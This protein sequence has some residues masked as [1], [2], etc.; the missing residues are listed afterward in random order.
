MPIYYLS[1]FKVPV[2][3]DKVIEKL[4]RN[5]LWEGVD[6]RNGVHLVRWDKVT[7]SKKMGGLGIGSIINRNDALLGKWIWRFSLEQNSFWHSIIRSKYSIQ[8]NRWDSKVVLRGSFRNPWKAI[9]LGIE[10]FVGYIRYKAGDGEKIR[11]WTNSW[12][13]DSSLAVLFPRLYR[14]TSN[15]DSLIASNVI[16]GENSSYS[17]DISFRR[18]FYEN[19]IFDFM[20]LLEVVGAWKVNRLEMDCRLWVGEKS[21]VL[22]SNSFFEKLTSS[23]EERPFSPYNM[24]WKSGVPPK[25]KV[26]A[27]LSTWRKV[28]TYDVLQSRNPF[29]QIS[30]AWCTLCRREG[31]SIDHLLMHCP[32]AQFMWNNIRRELDLVTVFPYSWFNLLSISRSWK[33]NKKISRILW[34]SCLA[35]TWC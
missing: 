2:A 22:S 23:D 19:E 27:W 8:T 32:F 13:G 17:W 18:N 3:V 10:K 25:S 21:G 29:L 5:F 11:F 1:V 31:E 33:G 12:V 9:S 34:R 30:Q 20:D 15:P 35:V 7:K 16:W 24:I 26:L 6:K 14:I 4:L 28:N